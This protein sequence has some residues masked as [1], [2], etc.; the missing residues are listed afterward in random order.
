MLK[1][2]E[3]DDLMT[4]SR[5]YDTLAKNRSRMTP[6]NTFFRQ[7]D[8]ALRVH[9][10]WYWENLVLVVI[11]VLESK[12]LYYLCYKN[13]NSTGQIDFS[14]IYPKKCNEISCKIG[15]FFCKFA[16][17]NPAKFAFFPQ[18]IRS[19]DYLW[20]SPCPKQPLP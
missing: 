6:A 2:D 15:R 7:N 20:E 13:L 10:T 16:P 12:G 8:A 14:E 1:L 11:L 4:C 19:P 17:E 9:D 18:P 5:H 3:F